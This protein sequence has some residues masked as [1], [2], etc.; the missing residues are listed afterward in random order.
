MP[1]M[2]RPS[3]VDRQYL[4]VPPCQIAGPLN[5]KPARS[6]ITA[7][8]KTENERA[9]ARSIEHCPGGRAG[10]R[11]SMKQIIGYMPVSISTSKSS[12]VSIR[13]RASFS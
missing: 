10:P 5:T 2:T 13:T 7:P 9:Q 4:G 11:G 1:E 8:M 12:R 6:G 3:G